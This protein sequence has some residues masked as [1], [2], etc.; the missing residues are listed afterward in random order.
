[1]ST[2]TVAMPKS[3]PQS[4]FAPVRV[5]PKLTIGAVDD[6]Y[7][8]E[9]DTMADKVMRMPANNPQETFFKPTS[10]SI[11]RQPPASGETPEPT[12]EGTPGDVLK[13]VT[14]IPQV[15]LFLE[16]L[17]QQ[18]LLTLG[19]TWD[20]PSHL[21]KI[22]ILTTGGGLLAGLGLSVYAARNNPEAL[23]LMSSPLSGTVFRL[24]A[25]LLAAPLPLR[26]LGLEVNFDRPSPLSPLRNNMVGFHV[27]AG[28]LLQTFAPGLGFGRADS[29]SGMGAPPS[30]ALTLS[31]K[32]ADC[33][34]EE[35]LQ[36]KESD[37][38]GNT[39][40]SLVETT[41]QSSGTPLDKNTRSFMEQRFGHN[42][43]HVK[44]HTNSVAAKSAGSINA[45]AYTSGNNI[46]FNQNQFSPGTDSGKKLLAHELTHVV[47]QGD[48]NKVQRA[49]GPGAPALNWWDDKS[50]GIKPT[51][52]FWDDIQL[53]FPKDARK[54][55]G[56]GMDKIDKID[57]D[58]KGVVKI[59]K[60]YWDEE[61]GLKRRAWILTMIEKRDV[62]RYE[63]GRIDNEDLTNEKIT[64]KLK[65]L[66]GN[67]LSV[68]LKKLTDMSKFISND[69]VLAFLNG[70]S[71][72][73]GEI[74]KTSKDTLLDWKFDNNRLTDADFQDERINTRLRGLSAANLSDKENKAKIFTTNTGEE[75]AKLQSFLHQQST[76]ATSMP[77]D[78]I[79]TAGGGFTM[80]L[81]NVSIIVLPDT[82]GGKGNDTSFKTNLPTTSYQYNASK[83]TGLI[84]E[85]FT[86]QGKTK[87]PLTIPSK[88]VVTIQTRFES[89][90][91]ADLSSAYGRGTTAQDI[92]WGGKTL[93]FH[94]GSHGKG[95]ID[96]I[97]SH[98][99]PSLAIGTVKPSDLRSISSMLKEMNAQSC[100]FVDQV[101]TTQQNYS[102]TPAGI[103]SGIVS[104]TP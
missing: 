71:K 43:S 7:E 62:K 16:N 77:G 30:T 57:C 24:P 23:D 49:P 66:A 8:R 85:F 48:I 44:I 29:M 27:D 47:Q 51:K 33:E 1:M 89:L 20:N 95:F 74:I 90:L 53:F 60:A 10:N 58:D 83:D 38:S 14:S 15:N 100:Q 25:S 54:F 70:D 69:Q 97:K 59:G 104:C 26:A 87:V 96:Y 34:E 2:C 17:G 84:T 13:A 5:Q 19:H 9:A 28:L 21:G 45:L 72:I 4:F 6:P 61:D 101:G 79:V 78:A 103:A 91:N 80:N 41:L 11:Q 31:R 76:T 3:K 93:R 99:F 32:C 12:R 102:K 50:I 39:D 37:A 92:K 52:K 88:L 35:R 94:E 86:M 40:T 56:T 81:S 67:D 22:G 36:R 73:K 63:D 42:F 18:F 68:Y 75:T 55:S 98:T 46:V 64:G 82:S 65:T